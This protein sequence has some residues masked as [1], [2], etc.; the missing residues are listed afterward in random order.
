MGLGIGV[1]LGAILLELTLFGQQMQESDPLSNNTT[2]QLEQQTSQI[3]EEQLKQVAAKFHYRLIPL[4]ETW[5]SPEAFEKAVQEA[6][7]QEKLNMTDW[8]N[9]G[10]VIEEGMTAILVAEQLHSNGWIDSEEEFLKK[11]AQQQL[12]GQIQAGTYEFVRRPTMEEL[13]AIITDQT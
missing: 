9:T 1:I 6:V 11:L 10:F 4:N 13:I 7:L 3:S 2:T 5:Y 8:L 12:H